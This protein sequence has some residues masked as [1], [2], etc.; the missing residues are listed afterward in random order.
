MNF[1]LKFLLCLDMAMNPSRLKK[2]LIKLYLKQDNLTIKEDGY[3]TI[4]HI[5]DKEMSMYQSVIMIAKEVN[6]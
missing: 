4:L 2:I 3:E 1:A 5:I 6:V